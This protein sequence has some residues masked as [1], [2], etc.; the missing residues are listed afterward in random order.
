MLFGFN[1]AMVSLLLFAYAT[2]PLFPN[3]MDD[4]GI[5][6]ALPFM[7]LAPVVTVWLARRFWDMP[8]SMLV[9]GIALLVGARWAG[10]FSW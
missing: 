4:F 1:V 7:V 2:R 6:V 3:L 10:W 5:L 8:V 9:G